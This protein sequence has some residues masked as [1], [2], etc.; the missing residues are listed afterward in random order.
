MTR[1]ET[2][3]TRITTPVRTYLHPDTGSRVTVIAMLR[4]AQPDYFHQVR[5]LISDL[6]RA[7]AHVYLEHLTP[8]PPAELAQAPRTVRHGARILDAKLTAMWNQGAA[9]GLAAQID[10][11]PIQEGWHV[12]DLGA[13]P[14]ARLYGP[15][16]LRRQR[17]QQRTFNLLLHTLPHT[18]RR[19]LIM[20]TLATAIR[21]ATEDGPDG[22]P[23]PEP[24][25]RAHAAREHAALDALDH[26]RATRPDSS[27]VLVWG[28][29]HLRGFHDA[30]TA[31]GYKPDD[32]TSLTAID[33][34]NTP[35]PAVRP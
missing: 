14:L 7:G 32:E 34:S 23:P 6:E 17:R 28:A 33:T 26:Q 29:A 35:S 2:P 10:A 19:A 13:V 18:A 4:N 15:A 31:R 24:I 25:R 3:P 12:H 9:L 11:L 27:F 30:L 1:P 16:E 21:A 5:N 22:A 20:R 8:T